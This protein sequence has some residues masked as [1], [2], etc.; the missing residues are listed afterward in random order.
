MSVRI[1]IQNVELF[2]DGE[3]DRGV[4]DDIQNRLSYIVPN[5]KFMRKYKQSQKQAELGLTDSP[6]DGSITI[7]KRCYHA[8][9]T[10]RAPTGMLSYLR[11]T[12]SEHGVQ[13]SIVDERPNLIVTPGYSTP[14]LSLYDYQ[15][16][17]V[18]KTLSRGRGV[19]KAATGSGKTEMMVGCVAQASVFPMVFYVNSCDLMYQTKARFEKYMMYNG[20]PAEIGLVGDG[21]CDIRDITIATVQSCQRALTGEYTKNK[22]D[23]YIPD[24]KTK[25][26][27]SQADDVKAMVHDAQFVFFDEAQH[28]SCNTIQDIANNSHR[29]RIRV[30]GSASPWRDDGLDILIEACFGRR[31][32]DISATF[33]IESGYLVPPQITFHHFSHGTSVAQ[34]YN[35]HYKDLVVNNDYRNRWIADRARMHMNNGRLTIILVKWSTHAEILKELLPEVEVLTSSGKHKKSAKKRDDILEAMRRREV[36]GSIGTTLL[37]EGVDVPSAAAGIFAGGGKS[38]TRELQRVGRFIRRDPM[39]PDKTM[40]WIDEIYDHDRKYLMW[41]AR[42]RREILET[43]PAFDIGDMQVI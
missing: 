7:A 8:G 22:D 29:A 23:D 11:E 32:C 4:R 19:I 20:Q 2:V 37:D 21:K 43:E 42:R 30:G 25:F 27:T 36:M 1:R 28:V 18:N 38:S 3:L 35:S 34:N 39:D 26:T 6:W 16:E 13:Y 15:A 33:L 40:A 9:A 5:F 41:Q 12:L 24:D 31:I 14:D 10:L 17:V